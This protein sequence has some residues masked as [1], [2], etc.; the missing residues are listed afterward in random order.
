MLK[1]DK[2]LVCKTRLEASRINEANK[3]KAKYF[4]ADFYLKNTR[5]FGIIIEK[6]SGNYF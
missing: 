6:P 3:K 1:K 4:V 5:D 2:K